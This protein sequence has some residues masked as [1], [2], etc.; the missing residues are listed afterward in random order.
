MDESHLIA[1]D[2]RGFGDSDQIT[3]SES[4]L[5]IDAL[6]AY[7]YIHKTL[8]VPH[9]KII[10]I[11]HSL[12]SGV[13]TY[14][15]R[16]L[17][18]RGIRPGGLM[19]VSA[20]LS[21]PDAAMAYPMIPLLYPFKNIP[22]MR[23]YVRRV[24][25]EKWESDVSLGGHAFD[26]DSSNE[27]A[28]LTSSLLKSSEGGVACPIFIVHGGSDVEIPVKNG[29]GLFIQA[30]KGH[31]LVESQQ[32]SPSLS[33]TKKLDAVFL[34]RDAR[35]SGISKHDGFTIRPIGGEAHLW[36]E[37]DETKDS[38]GHVWFLEIRHGGHN[39]IQNFEIMTHAFSEWLSLNKI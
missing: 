2:Y 5:Q 12:G 27:S 1:I 17:T 14:L 8:S 25:S 13:A 29:R 28:T 15:A 6:S 38:S 7:D 3:P 34:P 32:T 10:I 16:Q 4:G 9:E 11:G 35:P 21:I 30:V 24:L 23:Q 39:N 19:L 36:T 22:M 20:Y 31:M 26:F 18:V 33:I 37:S